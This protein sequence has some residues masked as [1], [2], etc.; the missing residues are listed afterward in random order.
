MFSQ[1]KALGGELIFSESVRNVMQMRPQEIKSLQ[2]I[3][4]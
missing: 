3:L 4:I 1:L 2:K